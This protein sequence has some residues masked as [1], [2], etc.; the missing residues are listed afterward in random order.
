MKQKVFGIGLQ[1]TGTTTLMECLRAVD[2]KVAEFSMNLLFDYRLGKSIPTI[3]YLMNFD[4]AQ[5]LPYALQ[6]KELDK[7]FPNSKFILTTRKDEE[8]WYKSKMY[9]GLRGEPVHIR[10]KVMI[11][12][13]VYG[14]PAALTDKI[15]FMNKYNE[16]NE[17]VREYFKNKDNFLEICWEKGD[18]YETVYKFL[19]LKEP[20]PEIPENEPIVYPT[21]KKLLIKAESDPNR[22]FN[23]DTDMDIGYLDG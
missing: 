20:Y 7:S 15:R 5:D 4:A 1:R 10:N 13:M 12:L 3:I 22:Y 19:G 11:N 17:R 16:H 2:Y 6:Y 9:H 23:V 14:K 21:Y 18:T 8:T